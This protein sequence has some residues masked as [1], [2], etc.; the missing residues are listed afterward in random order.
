MILSLAECGDVA[1]ATA[2]VMEAP[3][4]H[5]LNPKIIAETQIG[6]NA[7]RV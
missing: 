6:D 3:W 1:D 7:L 2:M 4:T 5:A